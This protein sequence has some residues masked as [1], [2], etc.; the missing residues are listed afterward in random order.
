LT[1][2]KRNRYID[3]VATSSELAARAV[4]PDA[5]NDYHIRCVGKHVTIAINGVTTV[6]TEFPTLPD[7]GV[8]AWQLHSHFP[9]MQ[10]Q[11]KGVAIKEL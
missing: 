6:D 3:P 11:F 8:I 7:E 4:K 5:F 10:V 2:R 9:G 1:N